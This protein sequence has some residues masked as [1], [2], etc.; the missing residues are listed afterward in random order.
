MQYDLVIIGSGWAG[1]NAAVRAKELGFKVA[2]TE[3]KQL[4]GT[5]LNQGCIPTK[6]LIQSAKIYSLTKKAKTFGIEITNTSLDFSA[7]QKRK[8][9]VIQQLRQGISFMLKG[10]D[11]FSGEA[12]IL[13]AD[14]VEVGVEK[15]QARFILIA[16]GSKPYIPKAL[17]EQNPKLLTSDEMLEIKELP[18]SLLIIGGGVIGAEFAS[19]FNALGSQVS[20]VELM[21]QLLPGQDKEVA[22]KLENI[23]KKKG[24]E[25]STGT[26]AA[27][28]NS[29]DYQTILCC[30]GRVANTEGLA[31]EKLGVKLEKGKILTDENL[32][33]DIPNIYAAGD[34]TGNVMLAHAASYQGIIAVE[35]MANPGNPKKAD[36]LIPNCIFTDPEISSVGLL[37][38]DT[39]NT[40][41]HK[42]D[43]LGSGMACILDEAEG[44]IKII[45]EKNTERIL[46]A[47]IIG[48][49]ATE[50]ISVLTVA[51]QNKI[52]VT[53]L[54][55]TIFAHPTLSEIIP[56]AL[57]R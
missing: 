31:L 50:L 49:R 27:S 23:F 55:N 53:D 29:A 48:S 5:C 51:I 12:C 57:K 17:K 8:D 32:R 2:I 19:L 26:D 35:N 54:K 7:I 21:P 43:L 10:I 13:S 24:I 44:F 3:K 25:V 20:V 39:G 45:S 1:F 11:I 30:I 33:T 47:S 37:V 34:C 18:K 52:T 40:V 15:L 14:T 4:G 41:V 6:A 46:G 36:A 28:L 9:S 56:E 38:E 22:K 42:F 16:C